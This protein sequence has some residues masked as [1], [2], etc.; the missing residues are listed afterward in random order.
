MNAFLAN[1]SVL[2]RS[3]HN[4]IF[5][6]SFTQP[7]NNVIRMCSHFGGF[8]DDDEKEAYEASFGTR[9]TTWTGPAATEPAY[10]DLVRLT[11]KTDKSFEVVP[12][13]LDQADEEHPGPAGDNPFPYAQIHPG[14]L[15]SLFSNLIVRPSSESGP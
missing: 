14:S 2:R 11:N 13:P 7:L 8:D 9:G 12:S 5:S 3:S 4:M 6:E 1:N 15:N 10:A